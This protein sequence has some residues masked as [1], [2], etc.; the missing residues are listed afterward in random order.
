MT[1]LKSVGLSAEKWDGAI[2]T[3]VIQNH[4]KHM[5]TS[6]DKVYI[7]IVSQTELLSQLWILKF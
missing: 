2:F 4:L 1:K 3:K 7:L 6:I 5:S